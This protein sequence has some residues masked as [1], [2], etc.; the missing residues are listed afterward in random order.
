MRQVLYLLLFVCIFFSCSRQTNKKKFELVQTKDTVIKLKN[1]Y[2]E[3]DRS[4]PEYIDVSISMKVYEAKKV[5][6]AD[7]ISF[8]K[9]DVDTIEKRVKMDIKWPNIQEFSETMDASYIIDE[10]SILRSKVGDLFIKNASILD[11][12][13]IHVNDDRNF[14]IDFYLGIPETDEI[15]RCCYI[16]DAVGYGYSG[17]GKVN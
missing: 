12:S 13:E 15:Y 6:L 9:Q 16:V 14:V 2:Y 4:Y 1:Y 5:F 17:G 7:S 11:V 10:F 8:L 3:G